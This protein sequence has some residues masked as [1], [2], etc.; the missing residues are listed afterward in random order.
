MLTRIPSMQCHDRL[1]RMRIVAVAV[2]ASCNQLGTD[3][4]D[5]GVGVS[6]LS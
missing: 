3:G 5:L 4:V 2:V 6:R 1:K